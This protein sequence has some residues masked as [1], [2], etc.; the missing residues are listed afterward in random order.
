[1]TIFLIG[2]FVCTFMIIGAMS[3]YLDEVEEYCCNSGLTVKQAFMKMLQSPIETLLMFVPL[4][5][6]I[7]CKTESLES[8]W[9][10]DID[11]DTHEVSAHA[12]FR[13]GKWEYVRAHKRRNP[14]DIINNN[15]S[16]K[17]N[18]PYD[19]TNPIR[20]QRRQ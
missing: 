14:D 6:Y 4:I 20:N 2:A 8:G 3:V 5:L 13:N 10:L 11:N 15:L 12:R 19:G 16:Y 1:M 9:S 7:L 18:E 17:G